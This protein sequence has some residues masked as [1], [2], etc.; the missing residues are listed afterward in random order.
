[1]AKKAK[2]SKPAAKPARETLHAL[3]PAEVVERE[4]RVWELS[5]KGWRSHRIGLELG[6]SRITVWRI[7]KR[8]RAKEEKYFARYM[9]RAKQDQLDQLQY[10]YAEYMWA[11]DRS[12]KPITRARVQDA[13]DRGELTTTDQIEQTGDPRFLQ[14][15]QSTL[16]DI[17]D[18]L[19]LNVAPASQ[20]IASSLSGLVLTLRDRAVAY[21]AQERLDAAADAAGESSRVGLPGPG[22]GDR[23]V[24]Q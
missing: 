7:M 17:R 4:E 15:A 16:A 24:P 1:M 10:I 20:E 2:S 9:A 3:T 13:G 6:I 22:G 8:L 11:W 18:L 5:A 23:G 21:E 12:K 14:G 19:G